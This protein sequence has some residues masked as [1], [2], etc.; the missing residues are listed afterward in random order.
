[1]S[2]TF[3]ASS[4]LDEE[5]ARAE[6][7]GLLAQLFYAAPMPGCWRLC[8]SRSPRRRPPAPSWRSRGASWWALPRDTS[9]AADRTP[10][11]TRCSAASA[12]PRSTC[13]ARTTSAASSTK[14]AGALR[15]TSPAGPG[16]RR[17]MS[18]T[19][20][21]VAYLLRGDALP[22]R[23]RR[24]G[25]RQPHAPAG[26]LRQAPAALGAR[27]VRCN[28]RSIPRRVSMPHSRSSRARSSSVEH[29]LRH[30]AGLMEGETGTPVKC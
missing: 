21:H 24:R 1:M 26:L 4:A 12:S 18:E 25:G 20:D 8:A 16:A 6:V 11:T 9:D 3:P 7:Y 10:N 14:A 13:S 17:G 22:D 2:E 23:R 19:E 28:R 27:V 29:R 5:T 30:A 15:T